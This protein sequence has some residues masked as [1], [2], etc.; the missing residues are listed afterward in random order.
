LSTELIFACAFAVAGGGGNIVPVLALVNGESAFTS[1]GLTFNF[2]T[3]YSG[4]LSIPYTPGTTLSSWSILVQAIVNSAIGGES[5]SVA[6]PLNGI[7]LRLLAVNQPPSAV[8]EPATIAPFLL[9]TALL[10]TRR[11]RHLRNQR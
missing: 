10:V 6:T 8:P 11:L 4:S 7:G 5:R 3:P 1:Y 2:T 9:A